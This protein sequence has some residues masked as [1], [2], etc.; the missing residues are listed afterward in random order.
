MPEEKK[1]DE[2]LAFIII[3]SVRAALK[4]GCLHY[5]LAGR[6]LTTE[7]DVLDALRLDYGIHVDVRLRVEVTT[8]DR[9]LEAFLAERQR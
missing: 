9:E 5:S 3:A 4:N 2:E 6:L 7:K 1:T 8:V